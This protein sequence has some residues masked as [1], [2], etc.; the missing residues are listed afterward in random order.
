[1]AAGPGEGFLLEEDFPEHR[2]L[3]T[4]YVE[5]VYFALGGKIDFRFSVTGGGRESG[6]IGCRPVLG[7]STGGPRCFAC[8][9][10]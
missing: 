7:V 8:G 9:R 10:A 1:M 5:R 2:A 6:D 4:P 3:F